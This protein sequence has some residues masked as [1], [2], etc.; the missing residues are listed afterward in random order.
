M[1][2]KKIAFVYAPASLKNPVLRKK[3]WGTMPPLWALFLGSYLREALP[4]VKIDIIDEQILGREGFLRRLRNARYDLACFSPIFLTYADNLGYARLLRRNG[5]FVVF[6]GHYATPMRREILLNRGPGSG[7]HCVDAVVQYDGE[8]AI[9]ELVKGT[10]FSKIKNL[11]YR[12][13]D[14]AIRENPV[15]TPEAS[16]L[17]EVDYSL[18]D[19]EEYFSRQSPYARRI[20]PFISQRGCMR[21]STAGRCIFCSIKDRG[22]RTIAPETLW[23]RISGLKKKYGIKG[24]YDSSADF[25]GGTEWFREFCAASTACPEKPVIKVA[26]RLDDVTP[27]SAAALKAINVGNAVLG[28]ESFDDG[29]LRRLRKGWT[30]RTAKR[31]IRLLAKAGIMPEMY[32]LAGSPGESTGSLR[33]SFRE[34]NSLVLPAQAWEA[35]IIHTLNMIPGSAVWQQLLRA[36]KKYAGADMFDYPRL[37]ADWVRHFCPAGLE[38]IQAMKTAI[39]ELIA[40]KARI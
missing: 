23:S 6:G 37:F 17:P 25:M 36:E 2:V 9:P 18:V 8:R 4:G 11:V 7:D 21:A 1:R 3:G 27:R 29:V 40:L 22:Y 39:R 35:S 34:L 12:A 32:L 28:V 33:R 10:A 16:E 14:G 24:L 38:E 5:A 19:L 26:L 20:I 15:E 13:P 30:C 31:G